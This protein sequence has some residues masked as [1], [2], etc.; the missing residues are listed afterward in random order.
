[1][2]IF[3]LAI[4]NSEKLCADEIDDKLDSLEQSL[5]QNVVHSNIQLDELLAISSQFNSNQQVKLYTLKSISHLLSGQYKKTIMLLDK[6]LLFE[7]NDEQLTKIYSYKIT[8]SIA[9]KRYGDA[10]GLLEKSLARVE[11][12][13]DDNIK[14]SAYVRLMNTYLDLE[15]YDEVTR[16][17]EIVF[18][19][20]KGKDAQSQCY[21]MLLF[22]AAHSS[23][24]I[25][26][27]EKKLQLYDDTK[28]YCKAN[29]LPLIE[30]MSIKGKGVVEFKFGRFQTAEAYLL[31]A[32]EGYQPFK[33]ELEINNIHALLSEVY[34]NL[35]DYQQ[36]ILYANLV[37]ELPNEPVNYEVK[38]QAYNVLSMIASK[39][40]QFK[41]AYQYQ[42]QAHAI[43]VQL[44]ND[45]KVRE[46]AYQM[47]KFDSA[48]KSR[49]LNKLVQDH[50]MVAKQRSIMNNEKS[51]SFMFSTVLSGTVAFLS[52]LLATAWMQ[53]NQFRKQAQ[54]DSLTGIFNRGTGQEQAENEFIQVQA[55]GG[56]YS[57][58]VMD[59]DFF[60]NINDS[61]GHAT[62]DWVLKKVAEILT[63][64]SRDTDIVC[65]MG[66]EEFAIFMPF[67]PKATAVE[68]AERI[69]SEIE[70]MNTRFSG[71]EF[72]VT[73]SFG[74]SEIT[75][76]DLSVDPLL[77]KADVELYR[78]K[79]EGRNKVCS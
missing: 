76:N 73:A 57:V 32:L 29:N 65:R 36:A 54:V 58:L 33:F 60:K 10:F 56:E 22:A 6:A 5:V 55:R 27:Y 68:L 78:A 45:K 24:N 48:E 43:S 49:E 39:R 8:A 62:G 26:P 21:T 12:F 18:D 34:F 2:S 13:E 59:L 7:P 51:S 42:V 50:E 35:Q 23:L 37:N 17:S 52:L 74:V 66:G 70:S 4:F 14:I 15:A 46:T 64:E 63:T 25:E 67:L 71:H 61:Y 72:A 77:K 75:S 30:A 47:A 69:R 1:M 11:T 40:G 31:L 20:N 53:R 28:S 16:L 44:I 3:I 79:S 41:E 38:E 19:L 9:L